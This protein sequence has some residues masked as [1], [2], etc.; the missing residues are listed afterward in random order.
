MLSSNFWDSPRIYHIFYCDKIF[1]LHVQCRIVLKF[2]F[3]GFY[4][5]FLLCFCFVVVICD[6]VHDVE[7]VFVLP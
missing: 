5:C 6:L 7:T 3:C 4:S 1:D 2:F